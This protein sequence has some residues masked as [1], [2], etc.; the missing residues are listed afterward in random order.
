MPDKRK[1]VLGDGAVGDV[2]NPEN[3]PDSTIQPALKDSPE[4]AGA[5]LKEQAAA[6]LRAEKRAE[7]AAEKKESE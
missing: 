7:K 6:Q 4:K 3:T 1:V 2:E 5:T